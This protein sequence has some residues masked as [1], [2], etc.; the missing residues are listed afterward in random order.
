MPQLCEDPTLWLILGVFD[1]KTDPG[2]LLNWTFTLTASYVPS[3][4]VPT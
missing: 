3:C 1:T 2:D 4:F